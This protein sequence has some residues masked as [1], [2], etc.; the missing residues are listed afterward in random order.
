MKRSLV[1][2]LAA[3]ALR[4]SFAG[5]T[6]S[7]SAPDAYGTI[8]ITIMCDD[9]HMYPDPTNNL[10]TNV[11]FTCTNCTAMTPAFC[12]ALKDNLLLQASSIIANVDAVQNSASTLQSQYSFLEDS[13]YAL[14]QQGDSFF[15]TEL[16]YFKDN[17]PS[18]LPTA[19]YYRNQDNFNHLSGMPAYIG[20]GNNSICAYYNEAVKPVL[21]LALQEIQ[22]YR[23]LTE[24]LIYY[25][26]NLVSDSNSLN[27]YVSQL[28]C[29]ACQQ[30]Q[31]VTLPLYDPSGGGGGSSPS[32]PSGGCPCS[33]VLTGI[34]GILS[35]MNSEIA[36]MRV[37]LDGWDSSIRNIESYLNSIKSDVY[38]IR[39]TTDLMDDFFRDDTEYNFRKL[40]EHT[41]TLSNAV[42]AATVSL[43]PNLYWQDYTNATKFLDANGDDFDWLEKGAQ[44]STATGGYTIDFGEY[45][46]LNW[47][48]RIE[49][50]LGNIAGI[51]NETNGTQEADFTT[52]Q[53]AEKELVEGDLASSKFDLDNHV[54]PLRSVFSKIQQANINPFKNIF[55]GSYSEKITLLPNV[56][57]GSKESFNSL[58]PDQEI[59]TIE[60]DLGYTGNGSYG[61]SDLVEL[62]HNLTTFLWFVLI[63]LLDFVCF[64][65]FFKALVK[66]FEW[67]HKIGLAW[68]H[69]LLNGGAS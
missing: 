67:Y 46:Q 28:D 20:S 24:N 13:V 39:Q 32:T 5:C 31:T 30:S 34:Q 50:L 36:L 58:I 26:G 21:N 42:F 69:S 66:I 53:Q 4:L 68:A 35:S 64:L 33:E 59:P 19:P 6:I 7:E 18:S 14:K 43:P 2:I 40:I 44:I 49:Y 10:T 52:A 23:S 12:A 22:G 48:Q 25:V 63:M 51:F 60:V 15:V 61:I 27:D 29:S 45:G 17:S 62:A 37:R 41:L 57:L 65:W 56:S 55:S 47:F 9:Y 3:L 8:W 54:S 16:D 11:T 38:K 1:A